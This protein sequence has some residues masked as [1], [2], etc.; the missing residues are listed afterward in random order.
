MKILLMGNP[1]VG[2]SA[3][4]SRL[5]GV[6][7][8]CSNYPGTTVS[9]CEG[10]MPYEGDWAKLID[11]PGTY[12]LDPKSRVEEVAT[13]MIDEG[14]VIIDVVDA[15]NLE[16]N[17]YL[18]L[19]L[20]ESGK[21]VIIALNMWDDTSH[22]GV[23]ID[24]EKL[25]EK[26]GA[27]VV[28]TA[29]ITGEG[30]KKLVER[31]SEA[32][33]PKKT[34]QSEHERWDRIGE[35]IGGVQKLT[36]RH[37]T[38]V[39]RLEDASVNPVTGIP[40]AALVLGLSFL[41]IIQTGE[42][43][44][45]NIL[46]PFFYKI[47]GPFITNLVTGFVPEGVLREILLGEETNFVDSLGVLTTGLYV[48][49]DMVLP[50]VILFYFTL[51][52][53]EDSGYLPRLATLMDTLM[54]KIG[55][56][57]SAIV[58]SILGLGCNVPGMLSTRILESKKQRLIAATLISICIPCLA[59]NAIIISLL[60]NYGPQYVAIVY[61]VLILLYIILGFSLNRILPGKTPE[62]LL[63]VPPY[64]LPRLQPALKKTWM[65]VKH[66]LLE[67]VPYVLFG[68]L[69]VN[70]AYNFGFIEV[71]TRLFGPFISQV[72]G[73]PQEAVFA[74]IV[75]FLRKDVAVGMLAPL[76]M[77]AMQLTVASTI[78]AIYFPCIATYMVLF[79][80]LG[81]KDTMKSTAVMMLVA[82][83]VGFILKTLLL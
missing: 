23:D 67:A 16:R 81:L 60:L 77:T 43:A 13:K 51:S 27:P 24:V 1:N 55:L 7:V 52:L 80:E 50:F 54:H 59:Q 71:F 2:K 33:P 76:G 68:V 5:T 29:A 41:F 10:N 62:I 64:R 70:L 25:E 44:I 82:V 34:P 38:L 20:L 73:L 17:L 19:Q 48:P 69:L 8:L 39:E 31:L 72:F 30:V 83:A 47:Y 79:K 32:Q 3:L 6:Q 74:L 4:F 75:G 65:R 22:V 45:E 28:P 26:L 58:P 37:H 46:D 9:Y 53:L 63:E 11:V 14:D 35:I 61:A 57:G 56:H 42:W 36:H 40:I 66:F 18:T 21:P 15:T 49:L 78:L 12:S